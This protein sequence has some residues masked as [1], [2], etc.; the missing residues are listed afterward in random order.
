MWVLTLGALVV[1][2]VG[3]L[4]VVAPLVVVLV[5]VVTLLLGCGHGR[6]LVVSPPIRILRGTKLVSC[7]C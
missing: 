3:P 2:V 4:G 7:C 6:C 5:V 1:L